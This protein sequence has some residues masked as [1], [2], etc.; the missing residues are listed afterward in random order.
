M[1]LARIALVYCLIISTTSARAQSAEAQAD[2]LFHRGRNFMTTGRVAE[3]C[4]AF[5]ESQKLDP[6]PTTLIN[7]AACREKLGQ[8]ATAWRL[9]L[10]AE[11][12]TQSA[13]DE[14]SAQ[15]HKI[16]FDR[17]ANLEPGVPKLMIRVS[18]RSN[19]DRLEILRD[20][21]LVP[22][23]MWNR[24]IKIDGGTYTFTARAPGVSEWSTHVT[25]SAEAQGDEMT[26]DIP[27]LRDNRPRLV[28]PSEA[29]GTRQRR[30]A[31]WKPWTIV[32][33]GGIL[34][35]AS[36]WV[37]GLA[38]RNFQTFDESFQRLNCWVESHACM[39][40]QFSSGMKDLVTHAR[41]QQTIAV[42][43]YL[44]GGSLIA[45]GATLLYLNRSRPTEQMSS[46]M[47]YRSVAVVPTLSDGLLGVLLSVN[48]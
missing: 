44:I 11:R 39:S 46:K 35:A 41:R 40:E 16:A 29:T 6:A 18:D 38:Y 4:A 20:G 21:E 9:F 26:V 30:W 24:T 13:T 27:D 5:E 1:I 23:G 31:I 10:D 43:G 28:T 34:V 7:L 3:A 36:G 47:A 25:L 45:A 12:Q 14:V 19:V 17:A 33:G 42:G 48:H 2:I 22:K 32:A 8:L 37:H 15:L